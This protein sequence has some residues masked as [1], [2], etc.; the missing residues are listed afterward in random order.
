MSKPSIIIRRDATRAFTTT[1]YEC[2]VECTRIEQE[3]R[4]LQDLQWEYGYAPRRADKISDLRQELQA[5][6]RE[7]DRLNTFRRGE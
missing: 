1:R 4:R 3:M 6:S 2:L 5:W 7:A